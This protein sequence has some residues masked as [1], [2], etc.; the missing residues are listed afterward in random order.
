MTTP[1]FQLVEPY[2]IEDSVSRGSDIHSLLLK[3]FS[4]QERFSMSTL[5]QTNFDKLR[6]IES[7]GKNGEILYSIAPLIDGRITLAEESS[8]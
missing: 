1:R 4:C 6:N 8:A 3:V 2:P 7:K 5:E